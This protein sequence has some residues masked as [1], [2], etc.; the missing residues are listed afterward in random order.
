[1]DGKLN[2]INLNLITSYLS[3]DSPYWYNY[4]KET[5]ELIGIPFDEVT[6]TEVA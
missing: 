3:K 2:V 1:M 5:L 6:I 4:W